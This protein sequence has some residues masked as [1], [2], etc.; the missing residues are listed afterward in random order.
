M[1][2]CVYLPC[3]ELYSPVLEMSLRTIR[4]KFP[5]SNVAAL[6]VECQYSKV[7]TI[8]EICFVV[9]LPIYL[10]IM[11]CIFKML[12]RADILSYIFT[13]TQAMQN[14]SEL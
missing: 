6:C 13:E 9:C 4:Q 14:G 1:I 3:T 10:E 2:E 7:V 8:L 12:E 11:H 5:Q